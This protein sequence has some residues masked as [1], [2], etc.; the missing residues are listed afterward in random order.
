M[1]ACVLLCVIGVVVCVV[2][3]FVCVAVV[4]GCRCL[5]VSLFVLSCV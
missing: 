2:G 4:C 3:A 5:C 1:C